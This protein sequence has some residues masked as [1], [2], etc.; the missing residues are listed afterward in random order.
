MKIRKIVVD[1]S[2]ILDILFPDEKIQ[3]LPKEKMIAPTLLEYEVV[4]AI[5]MGVVRKRIPESVGQELIKEWLGW[6]IEY[7]NIDV[8]AVMRLA[9]AT[10]LSVYDASYLWL[11]KEQGV[12]LLTWDKRLLQQ[13]NA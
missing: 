9:L 4:N 7:H 10:Q 12:G 11:A 8:A 3:R 6:K 1:A 5:K 2:Y 13:T